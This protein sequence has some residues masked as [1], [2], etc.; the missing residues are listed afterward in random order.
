MGTAHFR[1]GRRCIIVSLIIRTIHTIYTAITTAFLR[2][3]TDVAIRARIIRRI[4]VIHGRI[5]RIIRI[6]RIVR[7]IGALPTAKASR[8]DL[9]DR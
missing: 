1:S 3:R 4:I 9:T 2:I 7:T 5:I 8:G 6:V